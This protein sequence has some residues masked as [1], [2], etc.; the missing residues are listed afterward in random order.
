MLYCKLIGCWLTGGPANPEAPA[1]PTSP[2]SPC[3][4]QAVGQKDCLY[5]T[6]KL[7]VVLRSSSDIYVNRSFGVNM[8][9]YGNI[10]YDEEVSYLQRVHEVQQG[11]QV[12][13]NHSHPGGENSEG[14]I[15]LAL[16]HESIN[17]HT[18]EVSCQHQHEFKC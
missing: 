13:R 6:L 1:G 15:S 16:F 14:F 4:Q 7:Y 8:G 18:R 3:G 2:R 9:K 12:Q 5:C 11:Q 10:S 17:S